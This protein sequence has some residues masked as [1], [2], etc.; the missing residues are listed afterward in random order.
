[1]VDPYIHYEYFARN[2]YVRL[3]Y[4]RLVRTIRIYTR[5]YSIYTQRIALRFDRLLVNVITRNVR[6]S[7][8]LEEGVYFTRTCFPDGSS[9][10]VIFHTFEQ[11]NLNFLQYRLTQMML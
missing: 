5:I 8:A 10:P 6:A 7:Y 11:D 4:S 2:F 1:M 9:F 3:F